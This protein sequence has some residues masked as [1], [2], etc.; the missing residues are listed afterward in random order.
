M[1]EMLGLKKDEYEHEFVVAIT[2]YISL[3]RRIGCF[4][5]IGTGID[6]LARYRFGTMVLALRI[7]SNAPNI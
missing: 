2:D 4:K 3:L 6:L 5:K 7:Y 1:Y